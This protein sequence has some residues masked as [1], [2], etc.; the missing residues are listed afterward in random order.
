MPARWPI[1][2]TEVSQLPRCPTASLTVS[3]ACAALASSASAATAALVIFIHPPTCRSFRSGDAFA[4]RFAP[5]AE[6]TPVHGF[7]DYTFVGAYRRMRNARRDR[8]DRGAAVLHRARGFDH[9]A[10]ECHHGDIGGA[11]ALARAV[12]DR[13]HAFP[14]RDILIGNARNA[15]EV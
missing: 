10:A 11:D 7:R 13:P 6:R 2:D 12:A 3:S 15:G 4:R 9:Q 8:A 5:A 14:H 1:S